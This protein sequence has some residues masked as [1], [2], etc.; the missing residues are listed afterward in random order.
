MLPC[1]MGVDA[2]LTLVI[3]S[4]E[5]D[6]RPSKGAAIVVGA[7]LQPLLLSEIAVEFCGAQAGEAKEDLHP[8][9]VHLG[10]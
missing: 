9:R 8:V 10:G 5:S 4:E 3:P 2:L 6:G 1:Q 7:C